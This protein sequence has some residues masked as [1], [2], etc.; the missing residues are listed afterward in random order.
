MQIFMANDK[1][2]IRE[3]LVVWQRAIATGDLPL[4]LGLMADDVVFLLPG[5]PPMCGKDV[6]A[7]SFQSAL[8]HYRIDAA[9]E[10]QEI[11]VSGDWAYCWNHLSVTVTPLQGG[12]ATRRSGYTLSIL[13]KRPDGTWLLARDANLLTAEGPGAG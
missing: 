11:E 5:Q 4:L 7:A 2:Q 1:Q 10:V 12:T 6:F 13:R 3:L 8:E 9:S